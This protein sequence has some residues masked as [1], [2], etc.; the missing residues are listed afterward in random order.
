M[1]TSNAG[2]GLPDRALKILIETL[3]NSFSRSVDQH[4]VETK[5]V[6][7]IEEAQRV[8]LGSILDKVTTKRSYRVVA[9]IQLA[10]GIAADGRIDLTVRPPGTRGAKGVAGRIGRYLLEHHVTAP[11]D[12]YQNL[13]K[14]SEKLVRGNFAEFDAFLEWAASEG[15]TK[16]QLCAALDFACARVAASA[17]PVLPFPEIVQDK[18]TFAALMGL[19]VQMTGVGSRGSTSN[20]SRRRCS[21]P[22]FCRRA[23]SKSS[24]QRTLMP[25]MKVP[26]RQQTFNSSWVRV[27]WKL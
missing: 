1:T 2:Q 17:R 18:V 13:G 16:D 4:E 20:S 15:R 3:E 12:A 26:E 23:G 22:E 9:I 27:S 7:E 6:R 10:F 25:R 24:R 21:M 14:N 19:F 11:D 5:S 8:N